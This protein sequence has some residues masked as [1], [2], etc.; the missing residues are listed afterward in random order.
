MWKT[1]F[2]FLVL[3]LLIFGFN[4]NANAS[5][6]DGLVAYYPFNGDVKDESGH[7]NDGENNGATLT[8]DRFGNPKSAYSF[9]GNDFISFQNNPVGFVGTGSFSISCWF[10]TNVIGDQHII[11]MGN[12]RQGSTTGEEDAGIC[13]IPYNNKELLIYAYAQDNNGNSTLNYITS[14]IITNTWYHS[15]VIV[16]NQETQLYLDGV[17]IYCVPNSLPCDNNNPYNFSIPEWN[18]MRFGAAHWDNSARTF[19]NGALDDVRI[20]NRVLSEDEIK[21][22]YTGNNS[23][24]TPDI[25]ANGQD[26]QITVSSGTHVSVT[27]SLAP[28]DQIGQLADWFIAE[29]TPLGFYTLTP[30]WVGA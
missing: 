16:S 20:Y 12:D 6:T 5:L 2:G 27:A 18:N 23:P 15:V 19:L 14:K 4:G 22:L 17:K 24:P 25:K 3:S 1:I 28:G 29:S 7:G 11:F 9:D 30:F 8:A 13:I 21:Q 26:G 10:Q